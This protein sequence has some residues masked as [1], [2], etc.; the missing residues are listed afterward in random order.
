MSTTDTPTLT[1][2]TDGD[3]VISIYGDGDGSGDY[4]DNE[5]API[6]LEEITTAGDAVAQLVLPQTTTVVDGTTENAISGEY[7]SSS[8]GTLELSG[9]GQSLVIAGYGVNADAFNEGGA[10]VYGDAALAQSTS[11]TDTAFT[12]VARVIADINYDGVV[13]TST[14]LYNVDNTN[15]ARS[16]ATENGTTFYLSGQGTKGDTTQGVFL[17]TDGSSSAT[18]IDTSTDTRTA[19]IYDGVLYVSRDSTQGTGGTSNIASYGATLPTSATTA[20]PLSGIDG[21]VTLTAEQE[22]GINDADLG[23]TVNL[24]PENFF[25]ANADTLYVADSGDP[26][27]G[28]LGDGGL[29]KWTFDGTTWT[30]DYTLSAGL[31]LVADTATSGTTGLIGLTG[32]VVGDTVELFATNSTLGD[33]DQTYLFGITDTLDATT[34]P[35]DESFTTLVTAA[36]DTNIRG[37]AFAPTAST[38]TPTQ[39]VVSGNVV[40]TGLTVTSGST[41]TVLAGGTVVSATVLSGGAEVVS[42]GGV[43]SGSIVAAGATQTVLGSATGGQID[44]TQL[45]SAATAVV[46]N[47]TVYNGGTVDLYLKGA[48]ANDVTLTNGGVLNISGNATATGTVISSGG[49]ID[50]ESAKGTLAGALT[51]IGSGTL[52]ESVVVSSGFGELGVISGFGAGDVIDLTAIAAGGTMTTSLVGSQTVVVVSASTNQSFTFAGDIGSSLSLIANGSGGEE[53]AFNAPAQNS[54]TVVSAGVTSTGLTVASGQTLTVAAGGS[55]VSTTILAGGSATVTGSDTSATIAVGGFETVLG[56]A[57]GDLVEGTQLVS[58]ATATVSNETVVGGGIVDLYL[59]GA[60]GENLTM[61]SGGTLNISGNA[62]TSNTTITSGGIIDLESPKANVTGSLTFVGAGTLEETAVI[63]AGFGVSATISGFSAGDSL[64]LQVA[65]YSAAGTV[66]VAPGTAAATE[67]VTISEGGSNYVFDFAGDYT[68]AEFTLA[69][70]AEG[71]TE[72]TTT[73]LPCYAR[74]TRILTERGEVV[75][76]TLAV[77]DTVITASGG[78]RPIIWIGHRGLD[79]GRHPDPAAVSPVRIRAGAFGESRPMRDLW[80]S[81]RHSVAIDGVLMPII[82]LVNG[83]TVVQVMCPKVEYWHIELDAHDVVLA[84]GQAAESYLDNGNRTAFLNGGAFID[85]HPDFAPKH[86]QDTCLPLVTEGALLDRTR[87]NLL[88]RATVLGYAIDADHDV[89]LVVDGVRIEP[90]QIGEAR[91][92]FT[93]PLDGTEATLV[94]RC[95]VPAQTV[96]FGRDV[97]SLGV[98][99]MRLQ[100]D[101][102]DVSLDDD[103]A[104]SDGWHA[105]ERDGGLTTRRW[106]QGMARLPSRGSLIVI[107]LAGR[108]YYWAERQEQAIALAG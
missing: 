4:T 83:S 89:H 33:L 43:D 27:A 48:S 93:L 44:G 22:N 17:A 26:K 9:D 72:L 85:A 39:T 65:P 47:E 13:D 94:S 105:L 71:G 101:G 5:A 54:G 81:P 7:G 18:A 16:V 100:I 41:L 91:F 12:P 64:D 51:F 68:A 88:E 53:I 35:T 98:C 74:G 75:V 34:L 3:L 25:F 61:S 102:E 57:A 8:E 29:Q 20:V 73:Y 84:E 80:L 60:V 62:T 92:A 82:D 69:Q 86:W 63:S 87:A 31:D 49:L 36:A 1:A 14:A 32:E 52:E 11:L 42:A 77:G 108:G 99:V 40:S 104:F 30:L 23:T 37:V 56:S 45:V 67:V 15:N 58:A 78:R 97:R 2:F 95:F 79:L 28:G 106:T 70:D 19:E 90:R 76:E 59:K 66:S 46:S 38:A 55:I 10:A 50:I 107:D 96:P 6:T 24:S 103:G 21:T